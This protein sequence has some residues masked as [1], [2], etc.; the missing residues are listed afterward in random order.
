MTHHTVVHLD[1]AKRFSGTTLYAL[2]NFRYGCPGT[3]AQA[4]MTGKSLLKIFTARCVCR[5]KLQLY[6]ENR[7]L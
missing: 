1:L 3:K 4:M 7:Q 6:R 2:E 5:R